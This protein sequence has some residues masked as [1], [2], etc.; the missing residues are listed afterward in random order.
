MSHPVASHA[1]LAM[2]Q[3][4]RNDRRLGRVSFPR[5]ARAA[6]SA[7]SG[8][9]SVSN[10][11]A[12]PMPSVNNAVAYFLSRADHFRLEAEKASERPRLAKMHLELAAAFEK[13]AADMK[14]LLGDRPAD[15]PAL[16]PRIGVRPLGV[17]PGRRR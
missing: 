9:N 17:M 15:D 7:M 16:S 8:M 12:S 1:P 10:T 14:R 6:I 11:A 3:F 13:Q 5:I 4:F 2:A